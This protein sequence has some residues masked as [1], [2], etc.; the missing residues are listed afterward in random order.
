[1]ELWSSFANPT[2]T[3]LPT[4]NLELNGNLSS[5]R[6][7][8]SFK[9]GKFLLRLGGDGDLQLLVPNPKTLAET[10]EYLSYYASNTNGSRLVFNQS[11]NMYVVQRNNSRFYIIKNEAPVPSID[12]YLRVVLHFD[13][14]F[15]LYYH[16]KGQGNSGWKLAWSEPDNICASSSGIRNVACGFNNICSLGD[17]K[18]PKCQCPERFSLMDSSDKYGDCLSDFEMQTCDQV[19]NKTANANA[20]VNLFEFIR[21]NRTNFAYGDYE[22][23]R[24]Y[25]EERCKDSCLN[26][27]F[28]AAIVFDRVCWKKTSPLSNGQRYSLDG[29]PNSVTLIKVRKRAAVDVP[30]TRKKG[31]NR[32]WL[33]IAC[34]VLLGTSAFVTFILVVLYRK[35]NLKQARDITAATDSSTAVELNLRVFTYSELVAATKDFTEEL[36]RG[37]FG[38][39]YKGFFKVTADSEVTVAVKKLDRVARENEKEFN[40]EIKAIGQTHHKNL[41]RLIGLCNEGQSRLIVYEFLPH[42]TLAEYLFRRPRPSWEDRRKIA[43]GIARGILYLHEECSEQIIHCD[44]KPQN[45]LLDENYG[46]RISDFGLAK[47]LMMNQTHTLT[48]IR[49]TKGYVAAEWFRNS[50]I[51]TKVDVYS[52]GVMLLEIVCCKKAVDLEEN[53]IL[54]DWAYD[55]FRQG[56]LEDLIEGDLE[57]IDDMVMVERYVRIAIW[58]IHEEPGMR[59]NMRNVTHMLEGVAQNIIN[60]SVPVG[61]SLTASESQQFSN[62][63]LSPSGDF[64]FGFRKIQPNDG[65]TLSIWF[66]KI[67]EKTIVWHAQVNTTAG[68]VPDGSKV[69]LTEDRGLVLTDPRGQEL[70]RSSLP[71]SSGSV[72]RRRISDTGKFVLLSED[73][74]TELWSSFS[75]PTDTLLPTQSIEVGGNLSSRRTETSFAK[76]RFLLRLGSDGDLQLLVFNS[77]SLAETDEYFSYYAS[78]TNDPQNPGIRLVFNQSGDMY[79]VQSNNSRFSII[80]DKAPVPSR[81]FYLRAVLHFDGVFALYSHPKGQENSEWKLAWSEPDNVC[82]RSAAVMNIACGFNN[83]CSLGDNKR[84]KCQCPERFSLV[85]FSDEYGDC[86]PDFEMQTCGPDDNKTANA[87]I[88]ALA[89]GFVLRLFSELVAIRYVGRKFPLSFGQRSS[90]GDSDTFIKVLKRAADVPITEKKGTDRDWLIIG[91]VLLGTSAFVNFIFVA[92]YR[93]TKSKKKPNQARDIGAAIATA[94]AIELNLKVFTYRELVAATRNFMEE[95]GRGGFGIV[96]KGFL[97]VTGDSE[98]TVAVKKLDRVAQENENEVNVIGQTHHKN[99]VRLIGFCNEGQS[100]LIVYEFLPHGTLADYLFRR[101]R[102]NWED[103]RRIAVGIARGILY[104]HVECSEQIIH[105]DIKPQNILLDENYC[106]RISDFGLAKLL[107]MN[108]THTLTNIRGTKGYVAAEWFRNS[109]ITSKVD[110]YSYEVM[111]LEIVCCKKAVDL[112]DNVIL[113]DWAYDCFRQGRLDDLIEDDVEAIDDMET[114]EKYVK[115]AI[116]CIQEEPGMRPKMRNVTQML[117]GVAN[118]HDPPN[119]SPYSTFT[120]DDQS[121]SSGPMSLV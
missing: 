11:G 73:I 62:S 42:G 19:D 56:K 63:W 97:K 68:L 108:Q 58:C 64:A 9:K 118:V 53:V 95:L 20:D 79:V 57:A 76:G 59:P 78:N 67:L 101:P 32:L 16:P 75:N 5:R 112:E 24:N 49:G 44:I 61:Q 83:I 111:L 31:K 104:L 66:D 52:Y 69:T 27:C 4:Q 46:P 18:R 110:V 74:D 25:D 114:V 84:P 54:I 30:I 26:D 106:P 10:D 36:G 7:E 113:V 41:V 109:T 51:T 98:V 102:P 87:D 33:I 28:C 17:N 96:Y 103:R 14:V 115:I 107:M 2:D 82:T 92:L 34:P 40:N 65:F 8:T 91:S 85:D 117:E 99:L 6:T 89:T 71:Q 29:T 47:L 60:G 93:K 23:H 1:M 55:C 105:C 81:D 70:W 21:L 38:I 121:V 48:N 116:W 22:M 72:S 88:L 120:C 13:G 35:K 80:K 90:S 94:T 45:I 15:G 39:V 77:K 12:F 3:L 86:K 119:P 100:R 43:F 37:A 50:P